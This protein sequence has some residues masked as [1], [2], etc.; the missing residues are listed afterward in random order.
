[1][2]TPWLYLSDCWQVK[3]LNLSRKLIQNCNTKHLSPPPHYAHLSTPLSHVLYCFLPL[4]QYKRRE[5]N[6]FVN[7]MNTHLHSLAHTCTH[8]HTLTPTNIYFSVF[9]N[10][11]F[12]FFSFPAQ[13]FFTFY[14]HLF[15]SK[16]HQVHY[17]LIIF[18][19][20]Y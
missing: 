19:F 4:K 13:I 12:I 8:L 18:S 9:F 15:H 16:H 7:E 20:I 1:M 6:L 11:I 14:Q 17:N 3:S 10:I 5:V 2:T